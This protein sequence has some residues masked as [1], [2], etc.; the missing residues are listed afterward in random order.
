M[1]NLLPFPVAAAVLALFVCVPGA[2]GAPRES[3]RR[4][5]ANDEATRCAANLNHIYVMIKHYEH[6]SGVKRFPTLE[7]LGWTTRDWSVFRCSE[8]TAGERRNAKTFQ[9][10]YIIVNDPR[11]SRLTTVAPH[12][13][14]IVT[15]KA[16]HRDGTRFVLFYD[17]AV[18]KVDGERYDALQG[19]GFVRMGED[20]PDGE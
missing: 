12:D 3:Q 4:E 13:I 20:P 14:A 7:E 2:T 11:E 5:G 18:R 16:A 17:G 15:E 6:H 9:T 10:D 8:R 19:N 1:G